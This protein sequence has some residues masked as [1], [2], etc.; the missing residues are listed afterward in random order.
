MQRQSRTSGIIKTEIQACLNANITKTKNQNIIKAAQ[1]LIILLDND[2]H[3]QTHSF[4]PLLAAYNAVAKAHEDLLKAALDVNAAREKQEGVEEALEQLE[5]AKKNYDQAKSLYLTAST[6]PNYKRKEFD[7][8][9]LQTASGKESI[10]NVKTKKILGTDKAADAIKNILV[11]AYAELAQLVEEHAEKYKRLIRNSTGINTDDKVTCK[12]YELIEVYQ[13]A[14]NP[15]SDVSATDSMIEGNVKQTHSPRA[16]IN[17]GN[18]S[19]HLHAQKPKPVIVPTEQSTS[20]KKL[21]S[22]LN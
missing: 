7:D 1:A 10:K 13:N 4:I 16:Q 3:L 18:T 15:K 6:G 5:A 14:K 12:Y 19:H 9:K 11:P 17:L 2:I 8:L 20:V 21:G 22:S